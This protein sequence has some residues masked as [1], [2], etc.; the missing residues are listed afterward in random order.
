MECWKNKK[1]FQLLI[2]KDVFLTEAVKL[3]QGALAGVSF[4]EKEG[5]FNSSQRRGPVM[6]RSR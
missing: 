2:V 3:A 4:I 6:P 5:T 1:Q